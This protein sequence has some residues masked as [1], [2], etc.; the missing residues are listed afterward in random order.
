MKING[1]NDMTFLI[2]NAA[3]KDAISHWKHLATIVHEP[4]NDDEYQKLVAFL[5]KLLDIVG[6]NES[7]ELMGFVD[8]ISHIIS[9]YDEEHNDSF[10]KATGIQA[11]KFLMQEHG[12]RQADLPEIGSQGVVSEIL[13]GKRKLNIDQI[14]KL[15]RT[16][17][18]WHFDT[19][20]LDLVLQ[21]TSGSFP[22][23]RFLRSRLR[24]SFDNSVQTIE[25]CNLSRIFGNRASD[26]LLG[27]MRVAALWVLPLV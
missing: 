7:H 1:K 16:R 9:V 10:K 26:R 22:G 25:C 14:I 24:E 3:V 2:S 15:S 18:Y 21:R 17:T 27:L 6:E 19:Y 5:D 8:F 4:Q 13:N 11:L 23:I 12:L 20:H